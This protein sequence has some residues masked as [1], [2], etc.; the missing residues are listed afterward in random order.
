MR[1]FVI[2][3][4][5]NLFNNVLESFPIFYTVCIA[6]IEAIVRNSL[7]LGESWRCKKGP[8]RLLHVGR[9]GLRHIFLVMCRDGGVCVATGLGLGRVFLGRGRGCSL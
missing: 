8:E 6:C 5:L 9:F 7:Q 3:T 1:S 2:K 4:Y